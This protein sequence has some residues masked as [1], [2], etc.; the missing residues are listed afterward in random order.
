MLLSAGTGRAAAV[1]GVRVPGTVVHKRPSAPKS[2]TPIPPLYFVWLHFFSF[3]SLG[4]GFY[5]FYLLVQV[6][7]VAVAGWG[8]R[9][10]GGFSSDGILFIRFI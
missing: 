6:V 1:A 8:G 5:L 4:C 10:G 2:E 3:P 7:S 9:F